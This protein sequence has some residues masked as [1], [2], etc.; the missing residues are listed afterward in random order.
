MTTGILGVP[1][2]LAAAWFGGWVFTGLVAAAIALGLHEFARLAGRVGLTTSRLWLIISGL[3]TSVGFHL[4]G[5]AAA[6]P[7]LAAF[8][9]VTML[10]A[11]RRRAADGRV[12]FAA[13]ALFGY[14]YV[15]FLFSHLILLRDAG[16]AGDGGPAGVF[17]VFALTW[18][19]D[20]GAYTVGRLFGRRRPWPE[21]SPKKSL[22]GALGGFVAAVGAAF[23]ARVWFAPFLTTWSALGM[24][25][26]AGLLCPAADLFESA[27]KRRAGL[28]DSSLL[29]PGHGGVLDRFDSMLLMAPAAFYVLRL[30][31]AAD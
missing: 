28:K 11:L 21:L 8:I 27:I 17:L 6:G 18:C 14:V 19:C 25:I 2:L 31:A 3:A 15:P 22:E 29:L 24:G 13:G 5:G 16:V 10:L 9:A 7:L 23:L 26:I 1:L 20:T 30:F 4:W 12:R